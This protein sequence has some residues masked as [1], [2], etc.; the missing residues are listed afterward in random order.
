MTQASPYVIPQIIEDVERGNAMGHNR[1]YHYA[2]IL[3][4]GGRII[5]RVRYAFAFKKPLNGSLK[6]MRDLAAV[7]AGAGPTPA[8]AASA[9]VARAKSFPASASCLKVRGGGGRGRL[10]SYN[11]SGGG[12]HIVPQICSY[13]KGAWIRSSSVIPYALL[14]V[15]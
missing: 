12:L 2:D 11:E 6:A 5:G 13:C 14:L 15:V 3:G 1:S 8:D 9:A 7:K 4:A 10:M